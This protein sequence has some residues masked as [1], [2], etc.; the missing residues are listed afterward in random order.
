MYKYY[1]LTLEKKN[2]LQVWS[3]DLSSETSSDEC[4][5]TALD[6]S[7]KGGGYYVWLG[8]WGGVGG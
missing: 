5:V 3:G 2:R 8:D 4:Y 7:V 1:F 6:Q